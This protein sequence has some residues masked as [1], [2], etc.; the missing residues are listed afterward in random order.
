VD[1]DACHTTNGWGDQGTF[2]HCPNTPSGRPDYN[3]CDR[4]PGDHRAGKTSCKSCHN[5]NQATVI[6]YKD[7]TNYAPNCAG[8]H[9]NDFEN[10]SAHNSGGVANNQQCGNSC[11]H[12]VNSG[13]F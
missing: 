6:R 10:D 7:N 2:D 13:G 4:Y 12:K 1:C 9:A 8:C 3:Q 5:T 11:H